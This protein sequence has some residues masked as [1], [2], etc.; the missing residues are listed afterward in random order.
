MIER[1]DIGESVSCCVAVSTYLKN[2]NL[3]WFNPRSTAF[4]TV[5]CR[6]F[7][8]ILGSVSCREHFLCSCQRHKWNGSV[9]VALCR[10]HTAGSGVR[11][12]LL[13]STSQIVN[14]W[15]HQWVTTQLFLVHE[16]NGRLGYMH[17][18]LNNLLLGE[19]THDSHRGLNRWWSK[20]FFR[21]FPML[22]RLRTT[23]LGHVV[24]SCY[25]SLINTT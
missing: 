17:Q 1:I 8:S 25:F 20:T 23:A 6:L 14:L 12:L 3:S 10:V 19:S 7:S 13:A 15:P 21:W 5:M 22:I 16:T 9:I 11:T 2:K 24:I 18:M 4:N